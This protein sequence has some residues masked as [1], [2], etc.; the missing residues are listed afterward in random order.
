L[1]REKFGHELDEEMRLHREMKERE[2]MAGGVE[3]DEA[4]YA[5]RRQFG[6]A[7]VLRERGRDAWGWGWLEDF[8]QDLKFG[9]RMLRKS[10]GFTLTAV[11]TLALGIGANTAMFSVVS[12]WLLRPL[13]LTNPQELVSAWRTRLEA[14]RQPAYFN[15]YHDYLPYAAQNKTFES[16]AAT[17]EQSYALTSTDNP[18]EIH[19]A[20]ASW[21]LFETVGATPELGRLFEPENERGG[22]ACIISHRLWERAFHSAPDAIGQ[23]IRLNRAPY[24]VVGVLPASFSLRYLN[25]PFVTDAWTIIT[26]DNSTYTPTAPFPVAVIGR[27]KHGVTA[28]QAESDLSALQAQLNRQ[29]TDE[30]RDSGVL[31]VNLQ[32]D[33]T[34]TVRSSLLL[35]MGA[36]AVL[37][38]MACVNAGSLIL[39]RN[40]H[41]VAEFSLRVALGCGRQR[42]LRQLSTEVLTI[43]ALGGAAGVTI[44]I[45]LLKLFTVWSP[46]G[47]LPAGG[48]ALDGKVLAATAAIVCGAALLFGS[49][50]AVWAARTR[51]RGATTIGARATEP[52]EQ[53]RWRNAFVAV[54]IAFAAVLLVGAG[55]LIS[56]FLKI[57]SEPLGFQM[58]DVYV[59]DVALPK[60]VYPKNQD[61]RRFC[62]DVL[63]K[64]RGVPGVMAAGAA[65]SWPF[66]VD[67]LGPIETEKQQG[68]PVEQLPQAATFEVSPGYFEA[69]GVPLLKGRLFDEHDGPDSMHVAVISEEMARKYFANED[70]IGKR[71]RIRYIDERTPQEPWLTIA[72]VVRSTRSV[73]YNQIQ[74][75]K[76]PAV[77]TSFYQRPNETQMNPDAASAQT[78]YLYVQGGASFSAS[79]V[80]LAIHG[81]DPDLPLGS[82]RTT[83]EIVGEARSQ[84]RVRAI[85]LGSF[86][87]LTLV[88]SAIGVGGVMSQMVEQRR[89][90]IGVRIA[91]GAMAADVRRL[92]LGRAMRLALWGIAGGLLSAAIVARLLRSFLFGISAL[93]PITFAAVVVLLGSVALMAAYLPARRATAVDPMVALREE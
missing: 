8:A 44:A 16:L 31:V 41:R 49:L 6:N 53:L 68:Q 17:F 1:R 54:E 43:F 85:L 93:D 90:D 84:P 14:P 69:L 24:R 35:L 42:L 7:T 52:R 92:V 79:S 83:G 88:M 66:N 22:P 61:E 91:L 80:K 5:S 15:L 38:I 86:G 11:L 56:T 25:R 50:P 87:L 12:A 18:E 29:F 65:L 47:V 23:T 36:V 57:D 33:N 67:G 27:L 30:P 71:L 60:G 40:A 26:R 20:V 89:R 74:W 46:F 2:L 19:G 75:D 21:N 32:E 28:A 77:Y 63:N 3:K 45:G 82:L 37:L 39:G 62:V 34:R 73:R 55:L 48:V 78:V 4:A 70:P 51:E 59:G 13:P 58:R 81:V 9:A 72:G 64:L 76:Y 10:P